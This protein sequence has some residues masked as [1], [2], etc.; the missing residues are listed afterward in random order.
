MTNLA[1]RD[2]YNEFYTHKFEEALAQRKLL[3]VEMLD[4]DYFK[5][6]NDTNGHLKGDGCIE[7]VA[8]VLR[9]IANSHVFCARYGGDEFVIIYSDMTKEE[10]METAETIRRRVEELQIPHS[11]S[12]CAKVVTVTQGIFARIP[13]E[14][15]REWDFS[16]MADITLY[17]AK[18][19]GRNRWLLR[20]EFAE[21]AE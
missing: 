13:N 5:K 16:S 10:I 3:G 17:H 21:K 4:I 11:S 19:E 9:E 2:S 12:E 6:Y 15:N 7:A 20:T 14:L 18:N 8:G 1:N